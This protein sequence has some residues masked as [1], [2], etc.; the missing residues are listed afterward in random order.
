MGEARTVLIVEDE[1]LIQFHERELA[2]DAGFL[3]LTARN[4]DEALR[5]LHGPVRVDVLLTD[6]EMPGSIDGLCP[7]SASARALA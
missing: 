6:V 1:P 5:E 4:A 7:G 2:A 3:A